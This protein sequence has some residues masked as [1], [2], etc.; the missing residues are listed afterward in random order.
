LTPDSQKAAALRR[1]ALETLDKALATAGSERSLYL[2]LAVH[3]HGEAR[4][5]EAEAELLHGD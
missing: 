4:E 2:Q 5:A 3:I 1:E